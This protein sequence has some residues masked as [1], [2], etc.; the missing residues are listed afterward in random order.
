ML[1]TGDAAIVEHISFQWARGLPGRVSVL[2][3][4]ID[5]SGGACADG[6]VRA[7]LAL[8][9]VEAGLID[10]TSLHKDWTAVDVGD[11]R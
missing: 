10:L 7:A 6:F 8:P 3:V 11:V 2:I 4:T 1:F 5:G 9:V